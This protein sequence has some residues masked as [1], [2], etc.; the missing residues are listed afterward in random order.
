[1][2]RQPSLLKSKFKAAGI[3]LGISSI[4]FLVLAYVI[5][6][7]W[8][9]WPYFTADGGWQG[10][11][12]I[13]LIDLVL[14]P[15]LTLIIFNPAKSLREIRFDLGAIGLLQISA[16]VWGIYTVHSE[17]TAAGYAA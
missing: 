16:L 11:R 15:L 7:R 17:R 9:P 8:Y 14:G 2:T 13:A 6:F 5:I 12:I 1:M 10:I 3:H 4:I